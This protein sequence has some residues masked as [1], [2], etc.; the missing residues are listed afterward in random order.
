MSVG[1][2]RAMAMMPTG[3]HRF[4][5]L[6]PLLALGLLDLSTLSRSHSEAEDS[7]LYIVNV[8]NGDDLYHPNHLLFGPLNR[9]HYLVWEAFGYGGNA[10]VPMQILSVLA[11]LISAWLIYRIA[12]RIGAGLPLA[13]VA[14]GWACF[15]F[16]FWVYSLEADTY[17]L[18]MPFL[19]WAI[20]LLL[21][22]ASFADTGRRTVLRL[23]GLGAV[24]A[25]AALLHQQYAFVIPIIAIT[26]VVLWRRDP[27]RTVPPLLRAVG[28]FV[29]VAVVI[30]AGAYLLVGRYALGLHS[31]SEVIGWSRGHASNGLWESLTTKTPLLLVAGFV[32]SIFSIN[33]LFHSPRSADVMSR[34]FAGKS[35]VEERYLAE[36]GISTP[37]FV[38]IVIAMVV[39]AVATLWLVLRLARR[40]PG[41][42][43]SGSD[44]GPRRRFTGFA[45]VYLVISALLIM[46]WEPGNLEFWIAVTPVLA[47]LLAVLLSRRTRVVA[48]GFVLVGALFVANLLG[49]VLPYSQSDTDYWSVQNKGFR[50]VVRT[51]DVIVTDCPYVCRGNLALMTD[52]LPIQASS[53][54]V[55]QLQAALGARRVLVS[56]WAFTPPPSTEAPAGNG[57]VRKQ[58]SDNRSRLVEI[59][60]SGDQVIY[61]LRSR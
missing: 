12:L 24:V 42:E 53:D 47:L 19:L 25:V 18:P 21:R 22:F 15:S 29:T 11:S 16:G 34:V 9:I 26:F 14:T 1:N 51:G 56:S 39:A 61:E 8:T 55:D 44:D 57:A 4:W 10:T 46:I 23:A 49:A 50:E 3:L 59:G 36:H 7:A 54:D 52:V 2:A 33:F 17:L 40:A 58:L 45:T 13:L 60:R 6:V 41:P 28:V 48:A 27:E 31:V 37:A 43:L 30:T 20:L 38:A 32:R 5:I 35:L